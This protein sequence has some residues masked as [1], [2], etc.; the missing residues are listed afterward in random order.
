MT[1]GPLRIAIVSTPRSGN[2][3]LRRLLTDAYGL[4]ELAAHTPADVYWGGLPARC[5]LQIHW[6]REASFLDLLG[7]HRFRVVV[8]ARHPLDVL[9]SVLQFAPHEPETARWL[10]G[11]GGDES[12]LTGATPRGP[13]FLAYAA[14]PRA[15]ALLSVTREWWDAPGAY[16]LRYEDLVGDPAGE[17]R[18]LSVALGRPMPGEIAAEVVAANS[19]E[20]LRACSRNSH[21][22]RGRPGHWRELL[23]AE[24]A[25]RIAQAHPASFGGLGYVCDPDEGLDA[26]RADANWAGPGTPRGTH[27]VSSLNA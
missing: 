14:S 7:Q 16:P 27:V 25:R 23:T 12:A 17:L 5:V 15:A 11:E 22:W 3:W 20:R 26:E 1:P 18:R 9:V 19:L 10:E 13:A 6:R 2:S 8:L 21:F 4:A 24:A